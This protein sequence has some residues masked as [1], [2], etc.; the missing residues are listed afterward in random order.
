M[1][2]IKQLMFTLGYICILGT[3]DI[4]GLWSCWY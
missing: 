2:I 3:V 1:Y 4:R